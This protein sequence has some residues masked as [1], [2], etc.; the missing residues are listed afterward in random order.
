MMRVLRPIRLI[1]RNEELKMAINALMYSIPKMVNLIVVC[2]I[3]FLLFGIFGV[4]YFNEAYP[5]SGVVFNNYET[6]GIGWDDKG[7][8]K[9]QNIW[10]ELAFRFKGLGIYKSIIFKLANETVKPTYI[11]QN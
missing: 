3:F 4:N 2:M 9:Y 6:S 1:S 7:H 10:R 5:S 11:S 8:Y